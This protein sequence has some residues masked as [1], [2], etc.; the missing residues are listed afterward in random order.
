[1]C[2]LSHWKACKT[3]C[4]F[5]N[6]IQHPPWPIKM[7]TSAFLPCLIFIL[8]TT[9]SIL[10]ANAQLD[11]PPE[12]D[13]DDIADNEDDDPVHR[14]FQKIASFSPNRWTATTNSRMLTH[15]GFIGQK[16][17]SKKTNDYALPQTRNH[18][19]QPNNNKKHTTCA[20]ISV[21]PIAARKRHLSSQ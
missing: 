2:S 7:K 1:M 15:T 12:H 20:K 8:V 16:L 3:A 19:A 17:L 4:P 14:A 11:L 18:H 10:E 6:L 13:M 21:I 9:S 5:C